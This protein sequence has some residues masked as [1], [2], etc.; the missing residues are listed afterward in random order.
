MDQVRG[1]RERHE[2][3]GAHVAVH[4]MVPANQRLHA[5]DAARLQVDLRLVMQRDAAVVDR[6]AQLAQHAEPAYGVMIVDDVVVLE[7]RAVPLRRVHRDVGVAQQL[8]RVEPVIGRDGDPDVD[9]D[10][11]GDAARI[12]RRP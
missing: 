11:D 4:R 12:D 1:F 7:A 6:R 10:L 9:A 5:R 8:A 3:P 2:L